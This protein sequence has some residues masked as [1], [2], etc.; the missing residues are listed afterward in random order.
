MTQQQS[1]PGQTLIWSQESMWNRHWTL[2]VGELPIGELAFESAWGSLARATVW[3]TAWT[4]KRTGFFTPQVTVRPAGSEQAVAVYSPH[5]GGS[6]GVLQT[7]SEALDFRQTAF[8]GG[9]WGVS[10][11][12]GNLLLSCTSTG[13]MKHVGQYRSHYHPEAAPQQLHENAR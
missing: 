7:A 13:L 11:S 6:R 4:F 9:T 8:W 12:A 10:D 2:R 1:L 5:W 3:G